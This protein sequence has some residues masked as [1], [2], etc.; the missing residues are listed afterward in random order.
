MGNEL[1]TPELSDKD[2]DFLN[3]GG[4]LTRFIHEPQA[5]FDI[6][7]KNIDLYKSVID[8]DR[9]QTVIVGAYYFYRLLYSTPDNP[10]GIP[11]EE[12]LTEFETLMNDLLTRPITTSKMLDMLWMFFYIS[13]GDLKFAD[14]VY[15]VSQDVRVDSMVAMAATWS[16]SSHVKQGYIPFG[17]V[18]NS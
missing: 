11:S 1:S 16:Y 9:F 8:N 10:D 7:I 17:V 18:Y 15:Q 3:N 12:E 13:G 14:R 5:M 4:D 2:L 6:F